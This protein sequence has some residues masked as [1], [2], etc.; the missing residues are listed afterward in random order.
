MHINMCTN[1]HVSGILCFSLRH[2]SSFNQL[3]PTQTLHCDDPLTL[4]S[5]TIK[6]DTK[7]DFSVKLWSTCSSG[8]IELHD[9]GLIAICR[10]I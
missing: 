8:I 4:T 10:Y 7:R 5:H 6:D 1:D 2:K 9:T 3:K